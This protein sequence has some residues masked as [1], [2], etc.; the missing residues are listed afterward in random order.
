MQ[1]I[2]FKYLKNKNIKRI[3]L[4]CCSFLFEIY[5]FFI[6]LNMEKT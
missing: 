6:S 2:W 5:E 3:Q 1:N 4:D